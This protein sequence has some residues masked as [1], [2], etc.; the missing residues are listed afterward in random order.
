MTAG[1]WLEATKL[2]ASSPEH[3]K[4]LIITGT[5]LFEWNGKSHCK[6]ERA[7]VNQAMEIAK[8]FFQGHPQIWHLDAPHGIA[9]ALGDV[10][11]CGAVDGT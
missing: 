6:P 8:Q 2:P 1:H 5:V 3:L 10:W 9:A 4:A 7:N 11:P